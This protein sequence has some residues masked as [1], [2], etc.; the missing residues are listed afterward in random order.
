MAMWPPVA[1]YL[2]SGWYLFEGF[3]REHDGATCFEGHAEAAEQIFLKLGLCKVRDAELQLSDTR[4]H[5]QA[6]LVE[7]A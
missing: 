7:D 5:Q 4:Q 1:A 2:A 6:Q 3:K